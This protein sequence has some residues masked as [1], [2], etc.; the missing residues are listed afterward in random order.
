MRRQFLGVLVLLAV[1]AGMPRGAERNLLEVRNRFLDGSVDPTKAKL[2]PSVLVID[3]FEDDTLGRDWVFQGATAQRSDEHASD[4][5]KSL[6]VNFRN[7]ADFAAYRRG[8]GGWGNPETDKLAYWSSQVIFHDEARLEVFN[9]EQRPVKLLVTMGKVFRFDLQPGKNSLTL[10]AREMVDAVYRSTTILPGTKIQVEDNAP[11]KLYL[12]HFRWVGPGL[13]ENLIE[14]ARCFDA[15]FSTDDWPRAHFKPLS[16]NTAYDKQRGYG[17]EKPSDLE[18]AYGI[19]KT[20]I[21]GGSGRQPHDPL[22]RHLIMGIQSPLLVDLPDG[23]YRV[24]WVEG[25][26]FAYPGSNVA[27]D[28]DLSIK[29][30]AQVV[31]VRKAAR[32]FDERLRYFYG[33]DRVDYLPGEDRWRKYLDDTFAPL[34]CDVNVTGGQLKLEFLTNPPGRANLAF[35]VIY[36]VD[37]AAAIEPELA[38]LWHDIRYRL[39]EMSFQHATPEL[40]RA[41]HLPGLHE[42]FTDPPAAAKRAQALKAQAIGQKLVA[43]RRDGVEEVYPDTVPALADLSNEVQAFGPPGEIASLPIN[44]HALA[45]LKDLKLQFGD[46]QTADGAKLPRESLDLRFVRYSYRVSGQ[47]SHGDW[48]YT[49]MPWFLVRRE[50]VEMRAGMSVRWWLNVEVPAGTAA[51][52]Y[53]ATAKVSAAGLPAQELKLKLEVLPIRLDPVPA[54]I[55]FSTQWGMRQEWAPSPDAGYYGLAVRM[56]QKPAKEWA[57]RLRDRMFERSAAEFKLMKRY[58]L[59]RVYHRVEMREVSVVPTDLPAEIAGILPMI[60]SKEGAK[61]PFAAG[62][63]AN[64]LQGLTVKQIAAVK[65]TTG[66]RPVLFGPPKGWA[67]IQQEAGIYRFCSGFYLWRLDA[68]GCLYDPWRADWGDPYHPFDNHC[69]EWGSLCVP[70]SH[71]WPTLNSSVVLEGIREGILDYRY[72]VTLERLIKEKAEHPAAAAA[73]TYLDKLRAELRPEGDYYFQ[74]VG[75]NGGWDSTWHQKDTCWKAGD[76][77]AARR[78]IAAFLSRFQDRLGQSH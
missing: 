12:D 76:Y 63:P 60:E 68:G 27:C 78:R 7:Q 19:A 61:R 4:G 57:A 3:S 71:D 8:S 22:L 20:C 65:A 51:G 53:T 46:F 54:D 43:F 30:G 55:E 18:F 25:H 32:D 49:I 50:A 45:D 59:N 26:I 35:L 75:R 14:H 1:L 48:Q 77:T 44:L 39:N 66:K 38:A 21:V 10:K 37:R 42:E 31:P 24:H 11:V 5:K 6:Q 52:Q 64:A 40:A 36:P 29:A 23:K 15:A 74:P 72:L 47:Q 69:G 9:A 2:R 67:D 41:M 56:D 33:R 34:E 16:S 70:A 17:W 73:R 58:G 13:G 62:S 28:Y